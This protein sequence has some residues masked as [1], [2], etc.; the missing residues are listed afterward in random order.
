MKQT[1]LKAKKT[2]L[3]RTSLK[4]GKNYIGLSKTNST[5]KKTSLKKTIS[6][7]LNKTTELKKQSD[8]SRE[9]WEEARN[10]CIERDKGKCQVCGKKGT[11]VHHI[12][13]R[14]KRKDLLYELNNL[15]LL[16]D[17]HHFHHGSEGYEEQTRLIADA[18]HIS[19]EELLVF[20]ETKKEED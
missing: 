8:K 4:K 5:L 7:T 14:S 19:V 18:K 17:K 6:N 15:I 3:K 11:Q 12:H 9:L 1:P 10:K 20:A 16:C 13:L 2:A